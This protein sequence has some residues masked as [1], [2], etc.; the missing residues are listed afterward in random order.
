MKKYSNYENK[1]DWLK[2]NKKFSHYFNYNFFNQNTSYIKKYLDSINES[3]NSSKIRTIGLLC[4]LSLLYT[5]EIE[6][7]YMEYKNE[8][9]VKKKIEIRYGEDQL[10]I[11]EDK[12]KNRPK[13]VVKSNLTIGYWLEKGF[14][15]SQSKE[16]ISKIQS[17]NSK[18][19]H[20]KTLNYKIQ[21]PICKEY[22]KNIGFVDDD[23]IEELRKPY[24]DKC[25]NTLSRYVNKYGEEEGKK[26]F[27][28]GTDKRIKTLLDRYGT[29]TVTTYVSKESLRFLIKLYK[30]IRKNGVQ[31]TDI[32]WGI[33][34]SKEFVLTD[35]DNDRSYFYDFVIKSKKIIVEYNNLFWH[36]RKREEWRGIG[37]Y[38]KI[39]EYQEIKEKLAISRGYGVYYV[40]NDDNLIEKINYL[41]GLISNEC[42]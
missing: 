15:E 41:T 33:S 19:K 1:L 21:N 5:D 37:D 13:P 36:P 30:K 35:F 25:S 2:R 28:G 3:P 38:D 10:H 34:G 17:S 42:S 31:K 27:Y 8:K 6:K 12:L 16:N 22:W 4:D 20:K 18:K 32:V 23:E 40:W 26:I 7:K 9:S 11:Y 39:L 29:K 14:T 24:L